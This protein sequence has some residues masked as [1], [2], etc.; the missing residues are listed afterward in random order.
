MTETALWAQKYLYPFFF[1][2]QFSCY[3]KKSQHISNHVH[4][5]PFSKVLFPLAF[6]SFLLPF[7]PRCCHSLFSSL[8]FSPLSFASVSFE[9]LNNESELDSPFQLAVKSELKRHGREQHIFL[10]HHRWIG[11]EMAASITVCARGPSSSE[12]PAHDI[13][14]AWSNAEAD[15]QACLCRFHCW[16]L[17]A[18]CFLL[19]FL[20][21]YEVVIMEPFHAW[22]KA[23]FCLIFFFPLVCRHR[24]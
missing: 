5:L 20:W 16:N 22:K 11:V 6:S 10:R 1:F 3:I 24:K 7:L 2:F 19:D 23:L 17:T 8:P 14:P 15:V 21:D 4:F 18:R 13:S 9:V 12:L